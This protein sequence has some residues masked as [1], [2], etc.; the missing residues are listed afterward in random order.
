[1]STRSLGSALGT[2]G[3]ETKLI[4]AEIAAA[5]GVATVITSSRY[6]Q[7]VCDIIAYHS[8]HGTLRPRAAPLGSTPPASGTATP[9]ASHAPDA[10]SAHLGD[11]T[12][13]ALTSVTPVGTM[14]EPVP[15]TAV[16]VN[17]QPV[18]RPPHTLFLPSS[19]PLRDVKAW[20]THTLR[21]AGSVFIDAGAHAALARRE[22]GGRLLPA[23]VIAVSGAWAGGQAVRIVVRRP[24]VLDSTDA[25]GV[26]EP[27]GRM[28]DAG[29]VP[30]DD[31]W[32]EV[33]VGRGL[34]NYNWEQ[35]DKVKGKKRYVDI[36]T[37]L[38][39]VGLDQYSSFIQE[40]LGYADSEYV[41][42]NI[43]IRVPA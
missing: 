24:R 17:A 23:G 11:P 22:S 20:T 39:Y 1:M 43:T 8:V 13:H 28:Q 29:D 34:A 41:V 31:A 15:T 37:V 19:A 18:P 5:A 2:G 42:E 4:A 12:P 10:L 7:T 40:I 36:S 35:V 6:P 33:E 38:E 32:E 16:D 27:G 9:I 30:D 21:P 25:A 26:S 14:H 3:M